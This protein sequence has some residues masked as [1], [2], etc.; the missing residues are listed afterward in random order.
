[1]GQNN[2]DEFSYFLNI[3]RNVYATELHGVLHALLKA[4]RLTVTFISNREV[5]MDDSQ[6]LMLRCLLSLARCP[7]QSDDLLPQDQILIHLFLSFKEH[8]KKMG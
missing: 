3:K 5:L 8:E 2:Q 6:Y 4:T 7:S 1:M